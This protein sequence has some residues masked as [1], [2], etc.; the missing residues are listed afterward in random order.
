MNDAL[1][2]IGRTG[3]SELAD[4]YGEIG[5]QW[6]HEYEADFAALRY[7]ARRC[8]AN[9]R[10]LALA[11]FDPRAAVLHFSDAVADLHE[12]QPLD[13]ETTVGWTGQILKLWAESTHPS[14]AQRVA[15]IE[16]ELDKWDFHRSQG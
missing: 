11:G 6:K 13:K 7:A 15:A 1:A 16:L 5:F 9:D 3:V 4:K 2:N 8:R 12:M 14:A 10:L